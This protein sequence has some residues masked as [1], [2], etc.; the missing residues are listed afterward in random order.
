ME[1]D[2]HSGNDGVKLHQRLGLSWREAVI[3]ETRVLNAI[4]HD[5]E[6]L[7]ANQVWLEELES[8]YRDTPVGEDPQAR[9]ETRLG[10]LIAL[11]GMWLRRQFEPPPVVPVILGENTLAWESDTAPPRDATLLVEVYL[12]SRLPMPLILPATVQQVI[13]SGDGSKW[14][15]ETRLEQMSPAARQGVARVAFRYHRRILRERHERLE[16]E[17]DPPG[18]PDDTGDPVRG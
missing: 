9:T 11:F 5:N 1:T 13:P 6:A 7:L 2:P 4:M 14:H 8:S 17:G 16:A 10:L 15:I 3:P 12:N 18:T